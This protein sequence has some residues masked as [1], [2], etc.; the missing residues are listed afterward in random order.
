MK[1]GKESLS[2]KVHCPS[3]GDNIIQA[4]LGQCHCDSGSH[5][6]SWSIYEE[7]VTCKNHK[8]Y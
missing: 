4:T 5:S 7:D 8:K 2:N 6:P 3:C 1:M